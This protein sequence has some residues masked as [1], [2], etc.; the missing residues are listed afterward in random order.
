MSYFDEM[1]D[2]LSQ[3]VLI[4]QDTAERVKQTA[5]DRSNNIIHQAEQDA[6]RL[7]EEAKYKANEILVRQLIMLRK[8]LLKPKN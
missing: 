5:H 1:K 2:S 7:L 8:L 6:H 4:A 3:S